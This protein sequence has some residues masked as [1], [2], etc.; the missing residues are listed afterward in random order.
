MRHIKGGYMGNWGISEKATPKEKIKSEMADFLNGLNSVGD[1]SY[2]T[3]S[4]IFDYSMDL[5]DKV[6]DLGKSEVGKVVNINK[7]DIFDN[8]KNIK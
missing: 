7:I 3:Y 5:F 4:E 1:I 6:Y 2:S 8:R